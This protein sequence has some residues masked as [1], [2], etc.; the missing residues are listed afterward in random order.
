[1]GLHVCGIFS[2]NLWGVTS[3]IKL[4]RFSWPHMSLDNI[5]V[6]WRGN[7]NII[8]DLQKMSKNIVVLTMLVHYHSV[9]HVHERCLS[10]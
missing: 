1:M 10:S 3:L 8:E 9:L 5:L 4:N 2:M 6:P 7:V